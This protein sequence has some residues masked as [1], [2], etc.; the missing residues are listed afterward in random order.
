MTK[1]TRRQL[2]I[3]I[4]SVASMTAT[5]ALLGQTHSA[6]AFTGPKDAG[7]RSFVVDTVDGTTYT[8]TFEGIG[9]SD[10]IA[11]ELRLDE[12]PIE[13]WLDPT[14][15]IQSRIRGG[16]FDGA[17]LREGT[18]LLALTSGSGNV[19]TIDVTVWFEPGSI[20]GSYRIR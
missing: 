19:Q 6:H 12:K 3:H 10:L 11:A 18:G 4:A 2:M 13:I 16:V 15:L 5:T 14:L 1:I 9:L 17:M 7:V 20:A 8:I